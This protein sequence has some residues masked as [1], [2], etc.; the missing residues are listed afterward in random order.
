MANDFQTI[1]AAAGT[2]Y[3]AFVDATTDLSLIHI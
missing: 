3:A 2:A 1:S